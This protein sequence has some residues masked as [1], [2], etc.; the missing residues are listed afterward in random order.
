MY[1]RQDLCISILP[2]RVQSGLDDVSDQD[3]PYQS[4]ASNVLMLPN[5]KLLGLYVVAGLLNM[6]SAL[7][8]AYLHTILVF[9]PH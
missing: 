5:T 4:G 9:A 7:V 3:T 2:I 8:E 1:K 6:F